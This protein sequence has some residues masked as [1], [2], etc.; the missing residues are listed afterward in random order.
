MYWNLVKN[1]YI[2]MYFILDSIYFMLKTIFNKLIIT[3]FFILACFIIFL[4]KKLIFNP[5]DFQIFWYSVNTDFKLV[6]TWTDM[7]KY[8]NNFYIKYFYKKDENPLYVWGNKI[9]IDYI[10]YCHDK[11]QNCI[12]IP[13]QQIYSDMIWLSSIQYIWSVV[14]SLK[15]KYLYNLMDNITYMNPYWKYPYLFWQLI[16][17][18]SK[19]YATPENL[20][21]A[22][23]TRVDAIK[24]WEKWKIYNCDQIKLKQIL[25]LPESEFMPS[26]L[27]TWSL[28]FYNPCSTS[29]FG[30][31][32]A[33]NYFYYIA[34]YQK[35]SDNYKIWAFNDDATPVLSSMAVIFKWKTWNREKSMQMWFS[36]YVYMNEKLTKSKTDE[37][38]DI[39]S[40]KVEESIKKALVEYQLYILQKTNSF[41]WDD[42]SCMHDYD[43]VYKKWYLLKV[44]NN[45]LNVCKNLNINNMDL[46]KLTKWFFEKENSLDILKCILLSYWI[47]AKYINPYTWELP[48]AR[49]DE[50]DV[51]I[52][53]QW[54]DEVWDWEFGAKKN[55]F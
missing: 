14:N 39:Y 24:I 37:E 27:N 22:Q 33:F 17:P 18:T 20:S 34:D 35:S 41:T 44:I 32:L 5:T 48:Y 19:F 43:C 9:F 40:W 3:I 55:K 11:K 54:D 45:E 42:L 38:Y 23:K 4:Y 52:E 28:N 26:L 10:D 16:I 47:S 8:F 21:N 6:A 46:S 53:F 13:H 36:Q 51:D 12:I 31:Y 50:A 29:D 7:S 2:I 1:F 30:S 25:E 15:T 49:Q